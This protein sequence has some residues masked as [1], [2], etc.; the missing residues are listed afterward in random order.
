MDLQYQRPGCGVFRVVLGVDFDLFFGPMILRVPPLCKSLHPTDLAG[1]LPLKQK[2]YVFLISEK[3]PTAFL[4][5]PFTF[6]I[7]SMY[8]IKIYLSCR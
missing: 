6:P 5:N 4:Q 1:H 7:G 8:G 3:T 2:N